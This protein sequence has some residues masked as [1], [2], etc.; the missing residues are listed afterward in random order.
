MTETK[1]PRGPVVFP[2]GRLMLCNVGRVG[3]TIL[4]N[5]ILDAAFRTYATVDYICGRSNEEL[6]RNDSRLGEIVVVHNSLSALCQSLKAALRN[7]YDGF[8]DLKNH[9]SWNSLLIA[10]LFRSRVKTGWNSKYFRPFHRDVRDVYVPNQ[11]QTETMRLIGQLA[12]LET[13]EYKPSLVLAADSINWFKQNHPSKRPFIFLNISATAS[14]RTWP[15]ER[16]E[17]YVR[18][19]GLSEEC[20]LINGMRK[21]WNLVDKLCAKLPGAVAFQPRQFMDV[22]A[23]VGE[24]RLVLT[25]DTGVVH[26][27]SALNTPVVALYCNGSESEEF[28]PLST[29]QLQIKARTTVAE[30]DAQ[31]AISQTLSKGLP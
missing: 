17:Q 27:C 7:R 29:R 20:I 30:M 28:R 13:S 24:A 4:R 6:I 22:A 11:H 25:V 31:E 26:T 8:I 18:G 2:N 10:R 9:C 12:G 16:W 14:N 5:S 21:D 19:C 1:T 23:A 3:D 15:V